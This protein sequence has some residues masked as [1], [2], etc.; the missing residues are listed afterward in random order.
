MKGKYYILFFLIFYGNSV[1]SQD[2]HFSQFYSTPL[3]LSPA[4]S[5]ST[6]GTR[7]SVNYRNQWPG[8]KDAYETYGFSADHFFQKIKSGLGFL[9]LYDRKGELKYS[10]LNTGL[11]YSFDVTIYHTLHFRP[12]MH[13]YYSHNSIDYSNLRMSYQM[14][15]GSPTPLYFPDLER[16]DFV[17]LGSSVL[18]YTQDKWIGS[19]IEHILRPPQSADDSDKTPVRYNI[20][21]GINFYS[22]GKL[23][24]PKKDHISFAFNFRKT[25]FFSQLDVGIMGFK[26]PVYLGLW[27]RGIPV[28]KSNP[29]SD[30]L[31]FSFGYTY[32]QINIGY[33]YDF[34]ISGLRGQTNGSHELALIYIIEEPNKPRKK[35]TYVPCPTF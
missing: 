26:D 27:Y 29:G 32:K 33:S 17:D 34:T 7:I 31:I 21:G 28:I 20:F 5:G 4:F 2:E 23:L 8:I 18:L 9:L 12:A 16:P 30:A 6:G 1:F 15:T 19:T 10:T 22:K 14:L 3:I 25:E 24:K 11:A 35:M 13:F